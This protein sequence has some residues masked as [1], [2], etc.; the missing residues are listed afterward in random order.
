MWEEEGDKEEDDLYLSHSGETCKSK[1]WVERNR[2]YATITTIP[3]EEG[4]TNITILTRG[5]L[6]NTSNSR[7][8]NLEFRTDLVWSLDL[9]ATG[10]LRPQA[11]WH[12]DEGESWDLHD[13]HTMLIRWE[14]LWG[15]GLFPVVY[16]PAILQGQTALVAASLCLSLTDGGL[17]DITHSA[18]QPLILNIAAAV[19]A[20]LFIY[21]LSKS[22]H[23]SPSIKKVS[24]RL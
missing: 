3:Y 11:D 19:R 6:V 14:G 21:L 17:P 15:G 20:L 5:M 8:A 2:A 7:P 12:T 24:T 23:N 13:Y 4:N 9:Q 10:W 16:T 1:T 18:R 22:K